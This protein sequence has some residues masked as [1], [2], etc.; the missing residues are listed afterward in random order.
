MIIGAQNV[1]YEQEINSL[2]ASSNYS[3][4]NWMS[5]LFLSDQ[6]PR[7]PFWHQGQPALQSFIASQ[8]YFVGAYT[9]QK[10]NSWCKPLSYSLS[11]YTLT[12]LAFLAR[13]ATYGTCCEQLQAVELLPHTHK[14]P[15]LHFPVLH[16]S[17][18]KSHV[19]YS[20]SSYVHNFL[21]LL[22]LS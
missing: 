17:R 14:K 8:C 7:V 1:F 15:L 21:T 22:P 13:S 2:L 3:T 11:T 5:C 9:G 18:H 6:G 16:Y 20:P 12:L 4:I 19:H 10:Y